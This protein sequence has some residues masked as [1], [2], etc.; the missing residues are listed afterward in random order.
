LGSYRGVTRPIKFGR[1]PGPEPFSA[2][3]LGQ[4]IDAVKDAMRRSKGHRE[5]GG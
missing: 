4:D 3:L 2:P 5:G 1:T